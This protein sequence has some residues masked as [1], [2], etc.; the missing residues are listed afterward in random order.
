M[1]N[2][3]AALFSDVLVPCHP[4]SDTPQMGPGQRDRKIQ[5]T[6]LRHTTSWQRRET[7]DLLMGRKFGGGNRKDSEGLEQCAVEN[8]IMWATYVDLSKKA[9]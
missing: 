4:D 1:S 3:S 7:G 2:L 8:Q 9:T 6:A 5:V